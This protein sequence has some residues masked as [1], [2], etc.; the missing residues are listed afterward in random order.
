MDNSHTP[1]IVPI[2]TSR[3]ISD[4]IEIS[5]DNNI[6]IKGTNLNFKEPHPFVCG[7]CSEHKDF[8]D[9]LPLECKDLFCENCMREYFNLRIQES[10]V[11]NI[12]C[13]NHL[14]KIEIS[15]EIIQKSVTA[16]MYEKFLVF[17]KNEELNNCPF[18]RWCSQPDCKGYDLGGLNKQMLMC[19]ICGFKY[20]Y[21]CGEAWHRNSKCKGSMDK[22]LDKWGQK[23]NVKYCPHCRRKIEKNFGCD[24]MTC[25][26]CNYEWCWLCG[27]KYVSGH[28]NK[29]EVKKVNKWN[30]PLKKVLGF[31]FAPLLIL[32]IG[33]TFCLV[34][35]EKFIENPGVEPNIRNFLRKRWASYPIAL[36]LGVILTPLFLVL[37]PFLLSM[38]FC[39][40]YFKQ[41]GCDFY[42]SNIIGS[43][44]GIV[45]VPI[46]I[47]LCGIIVIILNITGTVFL[48]IKLYIVLRRCKN[49]G[50][51]IPKG[52]YGFV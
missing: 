16:L 23:N 30:P 50:F 45:G 11:L 22:E 2:H 4:R 8:V 40:D 34:C 32:L 18:L 36:L 19:N 10:N 25:I 17:K 9:S 37:G 27:E 43:F 42:S 13:P 5:Y 28:F 7:I 46:F 39:I 3:N 44:L 35:L 24:H 49:P 31:F 15:D 6:E 1:K 20:C 21:Y 33:I 29:C 52:R 38:A 41:C 12:T 48:L 51:L 26:K 14:C 47:V